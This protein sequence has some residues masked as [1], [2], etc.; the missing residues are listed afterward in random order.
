MIDVVLEVATHP[1]DEDPVSDP[2]ADEAEADCGTTVPLRVET[3]FVAVSL[4]DR[5]FF[6][7]GAKLQMIEDEE[8]LAAGV[9]IFLAAKLEEVAF[10]NRGQILLLLGKKNSAGIKRV[11]TL[12]PYV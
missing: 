3:I 8:G 6:L 2:S 7:P 12:C 10:V 9:C 5:I 4:I 1:G 11:R